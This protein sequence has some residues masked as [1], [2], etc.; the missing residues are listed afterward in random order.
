MSKIY[1]EEYN[2]RR[3]QLALHGVFKRQLC[4]VKIWVTLSDVKVKVRTFA[5]PSIKDVCT[6]LWKIN[7]TLPLSAPAQPPLSVRTY[8]KFWKS[9]VFCTKKWERPHL[10]NLPCPQN[11]HT[12]QTPS[13]DC[14]RPLRT[15]PKVILKISLQVCSREKYH[16]EM[17]NGA[18]NSVARIRCLVIN[19]LNILL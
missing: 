12:G 7:P 15:A 3:I 5:W 13:S 18:K 17:L 1:A 19:N 10:R 4:F 6:K 9:G 8:H 14:G 11:V 16:N 2:K